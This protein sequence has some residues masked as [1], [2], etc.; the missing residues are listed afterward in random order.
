VPTGE[1][2]D[3]TPVQRIVYVVK[4]QSGETLVLTNVCSHMQC[5][6]HWDASLG[7]FLCP[8]HGGLYDIEGRNIGGPPPSP[9]P[10]WV[11]R[12]E[13]ESGQTVLYIENRYQESV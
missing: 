11:H 3:D 5:D 8:C 1:A 10:Q 4:R 6:V 2:Y 13:N 9:L 12:F 7:Q